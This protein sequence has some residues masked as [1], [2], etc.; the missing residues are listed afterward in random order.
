VPGLLRL[1]AH[2]LADQIDE[3]ALGRFAKLIVIFRFLADNETTAVVTAV[4]PFRCGSGETVGAVKPDSRAHFDKRSALRQLRRLFEFPTHQSRS[5]II[6]ENTDR[7]HRDFV[8]GF[9]LSDRA[10][11]SGSQKEAHCKYRGEHHRSYKKGLFQNLRSRGTPF[12]PLLC[13]IRRILSI[14]FSDRA[15]TLGRWPA[16]NVTQSGD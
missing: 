5:L 1:A 6:L 9:G 10:P 13:G 15:S 4:E 3:A 14:R 2:T 16:F 7:A 12:R 8:A 11:V